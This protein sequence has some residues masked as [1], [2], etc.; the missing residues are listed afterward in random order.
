MQAASIHSMTS[1]NPS[2]PTPSSEI[3]NPLAEHSN[4]D[5]AE[6]DTGKAIARSVASEDSD[7]SEAARPRLPLRSSSTRSLRR[8]VSRTR[9]SSPLATPPVQNSPDTSPGLYQ[10]FTPP[11]TRPRLHQ[12]S[13][14]SWSGHKISAT[15]DRIRSNV[16]D[17]SKSRARPQSLVLVARSPPTV[18]ITKDA[19][20]DSWPG[21]STRGLDAYEESP[22][23]G[24]WAET[25]G[26]P[27]T[28]ANPLM[29]GPDFRLGVLPSPGVESFF[30]AG[31]G[32]GRTPLP[33]SPLRMSSLAAESVTSHPDESERPRTSPEKSELTRERSASAGDALTSFQTANRQR[34]T[35][36]HGD[37]VA[38]GLD[39]GNEL[40]SILFSSF[41][42]PQLDER[43][44]TATTSSAHPQD[45][46]ATPAR[47]S[48]FNPRN[49]PGK[50]QSDILDSRPLTANKDLA[51][52][53]PDS[54]QTPTQARTALP[55]SHIVAYNND[56]SAPFDHKVILTSGTQHTELEIPS[57]EG[58]DVQTISHATSLRSESNYGTDVSNSAGN[59]VDPSDSVVTPTRIANS[60]PVEDHAESIYRQS[61]A[62]PTLREAAM[63]WP[64]PGCDSDSPIGSGPT[65]V[66][67]ANGVDASRYHAIVG[68]QTEEQQQQTFN[69]TL[70]NESE[71]VHRQESFG[72]LSPQ[73]AAL[74]NEDDVPHTRYL[75]QSSPY[76]ETNLSPVRSTSLGANG[77]FVPSRYSYHDSYQ[78]GRSFSDSHTW[79]MLSGAGQANTSVSHGRT[80]AAQIGGLST[81]PSVKGKL[82]KK[83]K[84]LS[85]SP[86][87]TQSTWNN[88][89]EKDKKK[90]FSFGSLFSRS[91]SGPSTPKPPDT[92]KRNRL[93]KQGPMIL[94]VPNGRQPSPEKVPP[95]PGFDHATPPSDQATLVSDDTHPRS[96]TP[97]SISR[98]SSMHSAVAMS[99]AGLHQAGWTSPE[100]S[101]PEGDHSEPTVPNVEPTRRLHSAKYS[102]SKKFSYNDMPDVN[103]LGDVAYRSNIAPGDSSS[104][105]QGPRWAAQRNG[106]PV[107]RPVSW[108]PQNGG[109]GPINSPPASYHPRPSPSVS[110]GGAHNQSRRGSGTIS[111]IS[112]AS[113][114]RHSYFDQAQRAN[115]INQVS[116]NQPPAG[117][118]E[119]GGYYFEPTGNTSPNAGFTRSN[120]DLRPGQQSRHSSYDARSSGIPDHALR[121]N[122]SYITN[123][124]QAGIGTTAS[125][126][127]TA[128]HY[129]WM[130]REQEARRREILAQQQ[131]RMH[132]QTSGGY[133]EELYE[134]TPRRQKQPALLEQ[135]MQGTSYP[136]QTWAPSGVDEGDFEWE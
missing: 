4:E 17:F 122:S 27:Y 94:S 25:W 99:A 21:L 9:T 32:G 101:Y 97:L 6:V 8:V 10:G 39:S 114:R 128:E 46:N 127:Q 120:S 79:D 41:G 30:E 74:A 125:P 116:A 62:A 117:W 2:L 133:D 42:P 98:R 31:S 16:S 123:D 78:T 87:T 58:G 68:S 19:D 89:P 86:M 130:K 132:S 63:Q 73:E 47:E 124:T 11:I 56:S 107:Q 85:F 59:T 113:S 48:G 37:R 33:T 110:A 14:S 22:P 104:M 135:R 83:D 64:A 106:S 43:P 5:S 115:S 61:P 35:F 84:R 88:Q 112:G 34:R 50:L 92:V 52:S 1:P 24:A 53:V 66:A 71:M 111:S 80:P 91:K 93:S 103:R 23:S 90:R 51:E 121:R 109:R 77:P 136:G 15:I 118:S 65:A 29:M 55:Q 36:S 108:A 26:K 13:L 82:S 44:T 28:H 102:F 134:S 67:P 131:Q 60:V 49:Q 96:H 95:P 40:S 12:R 76:A 70:M 20:D 57:E 105:Q 3:S 119:Y 129:E 69:A 75:A 126:T 54:N 38:A 100:I 45:L 7:G 81:V 72:E 18:H